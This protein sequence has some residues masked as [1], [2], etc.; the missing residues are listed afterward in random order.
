MSRGALQ[1]GCTQSIAHLRWLCPVQFTKLHTGRITQRQAVALHRP[2]S[3]V[4]VQ[5]IH[6]VVLCPL[7]TLDL[8][9]P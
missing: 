6:I 7:P 1:R 9:H 8:L 5:P 4:R 2:F 3:E